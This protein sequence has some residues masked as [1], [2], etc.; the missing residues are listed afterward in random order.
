MLA[1][2]SYYKHVGNG[3]KTILD[4]LEESA[5]MSQIPVKVHQ[6]K[7]K[8]ATLRF[9]YSGGDE[10][11]QEEVRKAESLSASTCEVCGL[12]GKRVSR[13]GWLKTLCKEHEN[14]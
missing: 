9:Y 1:N 7:E 13:R 4:E 5:S 2:Y 8:F 3:W 12:L 11:F 14:D 6:I 10:Y